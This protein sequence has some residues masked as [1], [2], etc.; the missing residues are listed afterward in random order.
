M[1]SEATYCIKPGYRARREALTLEHDAG[2]YWTP[3]RIAAADLYQHDVYELARDCAER[4]GGGLRI[5][6]V[7]CGYPRKTMRLAPFALAVTAFDQPTLASVVARDFPSLRFRPIDLARPGAAKEHFDL[8][9]CADVIEHL[10]D[11]D[12]CLGFL[13][14]LLGSH[15]I[16]ILSTPERDRVRGVHCLSSDKPEHV[17]EWNAD[18]FGRY[19]RSRGF[20]VV[21]HLLL[22]PARLTAAQ[23]A[24]IA[25]GGERDSA[26]VAGCQVVVCTRSPER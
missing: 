14:D 13:R 8:V 18:E 24:A 17:R 2:D 25:A 10:L 5:A 26:R 16:L 1:T 23:R 3:A 11:P 7:G 22:P 20:D 6:D 15:G 4:M 19:V 12:P 21:D 9:V